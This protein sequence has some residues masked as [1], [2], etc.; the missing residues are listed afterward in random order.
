MTD[1]MSERAD[2]ERMLGEATRLLARPMLSGVETHPFFAY[3]GD[4][5]ITA[6]IV[7]E[8]GNRAD[9]LT[10]GEVEESLAAIKVLY[11]AR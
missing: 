10:D 7:D 6:V 2:I 4:N 9:Y 1:G 5:L 11:E 8:Y 3:D